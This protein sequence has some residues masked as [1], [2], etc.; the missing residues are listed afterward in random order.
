MNG[1]LYELT[2]TAFTYGGDA[3]GRIRDDGDRVV[4]VPFGLP[5]ERVRVRL[6]EE[7]RGFARGELVEVLEASPERIAP[8]C[9]HFGICGGCHYQH[10]P[11]ELQLKAKSGDPARPVA[12]HRP[13]REPAGASRQCH[14]PTRTTIA[15]RCNSI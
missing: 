8:R 10:M 11:Y 6:V 2:L 7:K 3:L 9:K 13:H 1:R 12:A 15:T 14:A 4:F 5:G